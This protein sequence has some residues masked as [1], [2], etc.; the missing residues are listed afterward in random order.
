MYTHRPYKAGLAWDI[1]YRALH[2]F[3]IPARDSGGSTCSLLLL[4]TDRVCVPRITPIHGDAVLIKITSTNGSVIRRQCK[5][6]ASVR[7]VRR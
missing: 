6:N 7:D 4:L 1:Q 5:E 3:R 2:F